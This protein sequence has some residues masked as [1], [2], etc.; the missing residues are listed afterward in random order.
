MSTSTLGREERRPLVDAFVFERRL[1]LGCTG[2]IGAAIIFWIVAISTDHW[3]T[4]SGGDGMYLKN[5]LTSFNY[6]NKLQ[7]IP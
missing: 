4:V 3:I 5:I 1:L 6:M 7:Q 2:L